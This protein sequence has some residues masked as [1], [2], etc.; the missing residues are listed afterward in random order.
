MNTLR[1]D[2]RELAAQAPGVDLADRAVRGARR[3][4]ATRLAAISAAV[5]CLIAAGSTVLFQQVFHEPPIVLAPPETKALPLPEK[6]VGPVEQMYQMPCKA[7]CERRE[8]R[9]ATRD[10]EVYAFDPGP[11][12]MAA[13]PDGRRIAYYSAKQHTI[14]IRDLADGKT[15]KAPL[16]EPEEAFEAEYTLRLS[17][18]GLRFVVSG[19]GGRRQ[20]N[21]LVDVLRGTTTELERGWFPVSV[22]DGDGPVVLIKPYDKTTKVWVLGHQPI[23]VADFTYDFSLLSPDGHTLSR[24]TGSTD[25]RPRRADSIATFDALRGGQETTVLISGVHEGLRPARMGAWLNEHQVTVLAVPQAPR[26]GLPSLVYAIDVRTGESREMFAT[27]EDGAVVLP[28][29]VR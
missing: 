6:G 5:V 8:W 29:I 25:E 22:A 27:R 15:W 11:G 3:R 7:G 26:D 18:D 12:P 4:R 19:W 28:G 20:P 21:L 23:T 16:K 13:T 9:L 2:L 10:G 14:L 17:H 1:D 24:L